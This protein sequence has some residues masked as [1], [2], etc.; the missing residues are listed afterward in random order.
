MAAARIVPS[1]GRG[2]GLLAPPDALLALE[3]R[4]VGRLCTLLSAARRRRQWN[5]AVDKAAFELGWQGVAEA[6]LRGGDAVLREAAARLRIVGI[7]VVFVLDD[8]TRV[9]RAVRTASI[10]R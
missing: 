5:E 8:E 2:P 3:R 4:A 9:W 10:G 7:D 6:P 1:I